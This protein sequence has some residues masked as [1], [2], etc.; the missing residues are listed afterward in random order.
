MAVPFSRPRYTGNNN[1]NGNNNRGG[2]N[3][4][5][6]FGRRRRHPVEQ[7]IN[8]GEIPFDLSSLSF[9]SRI[10]FYALYEAW[11]LLQDITGSLGNAIQENNNNNTPVNA[12]NSHQAQ[13]P[14]LIFD[15]STQQQQSGDGGDDDDAATAG[16]GIGYATTEIR[17]QHLQQPRGR[18]FGDTNKNIEETA[19]KNFFLNPLPDLV[20]HHDDDDDDLDDLLSEKMSKSASSIITSD[21]L[22][23]SSSSSWRELG[24]QLCQLAS[25]FE[26]S[27]AGPENERQ[28]EIF[29]VY[30]RIK[31]K[32]LKDGEE[33]C[34]R[35][36][37]GVA[38]SLCKQ[39]LLSSIWILL[40]KVI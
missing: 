34:K 9:T 32:A 26:L 39:I 8:G 11:R 24:S 30:Q 31:L 23:S 21:I 7:L 1:A 27:F 6:T 3:A 22:I 18:T 36:D 20:P 12:N 13:S 29:K 2:N 4:N 14:D 19:E 5:A 10:A 17:Q 38:K 28:R 25:A 37:F 40:K 16:F 33:D 35:S 15:N